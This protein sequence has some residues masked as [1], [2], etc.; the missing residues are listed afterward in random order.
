MKKFMIPILML[1]LSYAGM[2]NAANTDISTL[3]NVI[4]VEPFA[5]SQG[6]QVVMSIKMK[7]TVAIRGFQ[8]DL[9]LPDGV[10]AA[11]TAKAVT[12][13]TATT[14]TEAATAAKATQATAKAAAK[15]CNYGRG[16]T[17]PVQARPGNTGASHQGPHRHQRRQSNH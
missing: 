12:K 4:Y 15:A 7:N 1:C 2:T 6:E 5:A 8:F 14:K 11:K 13:A 17:E 9:Y 10:T 3:N 16:Y